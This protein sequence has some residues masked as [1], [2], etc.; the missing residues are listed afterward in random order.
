MN[1]CVYACTCLCIFVCLYPYVCGCM[2]VLACMHACMRVCG[3]GYPMVIMLASCN[4]LLR[5][6]LLALFSKSVV[7]IFGSLKS[8]R[9]YLYLCS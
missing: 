7:A 3:K 6:T 9:D 5:I 2:Y 1:V 8:V 4:R